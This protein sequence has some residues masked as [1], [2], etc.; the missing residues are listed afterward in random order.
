MDP[1]YGRR[2]DVL[3]A[4][5]EHIAEKGFPPSVREIGERTGLRS[6]CTVQRHIE[7]LI[8]K[9]YLRRDGS[10]ARTLEVV[11]DSVPSRQGRAVPVVGLVAAGAPILAEQDIEG[12]ITIGED[13][14]G[15]EDTFAVKVRGQS[16]IG[17]GLDD[18]DTLVVRRQAHA[19]DGDIVVALVDGEE[20]TVKRFFRD[21]GRVRLQPENPTMEALYPDEVAIL[22]KAIVCIKQLEPRHPTR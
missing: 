2:K 3:Q 17:A 4:I 15:D 18:G 9:G 20:A 21:D 7:V 8:E 13:L 5:R 12:Y 14:L 19:E 11:G 16:M 10:K 6:S 1:L 22:G